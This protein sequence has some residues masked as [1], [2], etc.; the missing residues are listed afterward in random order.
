MAVVL[1]ARADLEPTQEEI[2]EYAQWLGMDL[3]QDTEF[4]LMAFRQPEIRPWRLGLV[5]SIGQH[6]KILCRNI[7]M[8]RQSFS[9]NFVSAF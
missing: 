5:I 6:Q 7:I 9:N 4:L 2:I 8:L 1:D 3:P